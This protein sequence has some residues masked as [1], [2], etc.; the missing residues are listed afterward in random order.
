MKRRLLSLFTAVM[1]IGALFT[2]GCAKKV[3]AED[4]MKTANEKMSKAESLSMEIEMNVSMYQE[5][6]GNIDMEIGMDM[7]IIQETGDLYMLMS[8]SILGM[9]QDIELYQVKNGEEY[10]QYMGM[11][12]LWYRQSV[13]ADEATGAMDAL[14]PEGRNYTLA[15]KT[16]TFEGREVYVVTTTMTGEEFMEYSDNELLEGMLSEDMD[17]SGMNAEVKI[18]IDK[19]DGTITQMIM[20]LEGM[21]AGL[22]E[23]ISLSMTITYTGFDTVKEIKVPDDVVEQAVEMEDGLLN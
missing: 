20:D 23:P 11:Q 14:A 2:G 4:L 17:L 22:D 5:M 6:L 3:T 10:T 19:A 7:D 21:E 9:S 12:G 8:M 16:E 1:M 15:E 18:L 13:G